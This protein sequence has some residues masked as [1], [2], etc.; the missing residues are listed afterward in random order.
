MRQVPASAACQPLGS[1]PVYDTPCDISLPKHYEAA[2][3]GRH[4]VDPELAISYPRKVGALIYAHPASRVDCSYTIG[5]LARCLTFPTP[6]MDAAAD[7]CIAYFMPSYTCP[8]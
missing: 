6:E 5:M 2:L 3:Q 4:S 1:Y 8:T 7:R